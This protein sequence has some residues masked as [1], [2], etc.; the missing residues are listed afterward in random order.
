MI[1]PKVCAVCGQVCDRNQDGE[2]LHA[3]ELVG[4]SDH[5]CVPVDYGEVP[6]VWRCDFC[7]RIVPL[8][9]MWTVPATTF[10]SMVTGQFMVGGWACDSECAQLA[11]SLDWDGLVDRYMA[12]PETNIPDQPLFRMATRTLY[13]ELAAHMTALPRPWQAGDEKTTEMPGGSR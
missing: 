5:V 9:A 8:E 1:H 2:W 12:S 4:K 10:R 11:R 7:H 6:T 13:Q 3:L